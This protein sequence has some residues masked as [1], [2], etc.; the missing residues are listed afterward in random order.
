MKKIVG[1][2]V[3][4]AIAL[5]FVGCDTVGTN[6]QP[7][8]LTGT[9]NFKSV[10]ANPT[11]TTPAANGKEGTWTWNYV[12]GP[13]AQVSTSTVN[14]PAG[15]TAVTTVTTTLSNNQT[16]TQSITTVVKA[17]GSFVRTVKSVTD[18]AAT[19]A[20][21]VPANTTYVV[22]GVS[23]A[24]GVTVP[25]TYAN[26]YTY[27]QTRTVT[28]TIVGSDYKENIK[29]VDDYSDSIGSATGATT[30]VRQKNTDTT[31]YYQG[32]SAGSLSF[33][34]VG[35]NVNVSDPWGLGFNIN[36][37]PKQTIFGT[38]LPAASGVDATTTTTDVLEV[39]ADGTYTKTTTVLVNV[40]AKAAVAATATTP[41]VLAVDAGTKTTTTVETG[42]VT[43][44]TGIAYLGDLA[45]TTV[46]ATEATGNML[47]FVPASEKVTKVATGSFLDVAAGH[48]ASGYGATAVTKDD[49]F[50][51]WSTS[52]NLVK[53][54]G[55]NATSNLIL[56]SASVY[57]KAA[58][59]K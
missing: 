49:S 14:T 47:Y 57:V 18:V 53:G 1:I 17:D 27:T 15:G 2:L 30:T 56:G 39:K 6:G 58:A 5:A 45:V 4:A 52:F 55:S 25:A 37:T 54:S 21:V 28:V 13:S 19:A 22:N 42:S 7:V 44:R 46:G 9:W 24:A 11:D 31:N 3:A 40:P 23:Y 32:N 34:A 10:T 48:Y 33:N 16:T 50:S 43:A 59:A 36:G 29:T 26:N 12:S 8:D 35:N 38:T 41:A 51:P 20:V